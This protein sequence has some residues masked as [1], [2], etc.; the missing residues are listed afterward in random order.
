MLEDSG[1]LSKATVMADTTSSS[2]LEPQK[3]PPAVLSSTTVRVV[4][5]RP[6]LK[7]RLV[8]LWS[9]RELL[10]YLVR[11]ELSTKYRNSTMG[12]AWSML[13]PAFMLLVWYFV[14]DV[15]MHSVIPGFAVYL[16]SG[17]LAWN[18]FVSS[19][20]QSTTAV[21]ENASI[22]QK[23]AFPREILAL[24]KVGQALVFFALQFIVLA[25]AIAIIGTTPDYRAIWLLLLAIV[26]LIIFT[27]ALAILL[28]AL[29]VFYRDIQ[30]FVE[31]ATF[32]WFFGAPIVYSY[33]ST[34]AP[35]LARRHLTWLYFSDPMASIVLAF[36]RVLYGSISPMGPHGIVKVL[37]D[38][39]LAWYGSMV[40]IFFVFSIFLFLISL[41]VFGRLEPN[42]A[43]EL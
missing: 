24:A 22:V 19:I 20:M 18:L 32:A 2:K 17:L 3:R 11:K 43:E 39:S 28:S 36:Q 31:V 27:S 6:D 4:S 12:F 38:R 40:G 16:M 13:N 42:F 7:D 14:F 5:A 21:I 37:P 8:L 26:T 29:N 15:V 25:C 23:V 10:F 30:H 33:V 9:R 1:R 35:G 34:M 41:I